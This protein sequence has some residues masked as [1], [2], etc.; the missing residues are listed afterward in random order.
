MLNFVLVFYVM[1]DFGI[2]SRVFVKFG[3]TFLEYVV[4]MGVYS[5]GKIL[6]CVSG[7]NGIEKGN[8]CLMKK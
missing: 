5:V 1:D 2:F 3:F 7:F 6:L 4:L 8:F